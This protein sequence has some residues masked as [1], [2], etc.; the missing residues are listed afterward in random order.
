MCNRRRGVRR[1]RGKR[2]NFITNIIFNQT[3]SIGVITS[4]QVKQINTVGLI[5]IVGCLCR[6]KIF[7]PTVMF[8]KDNFSIP[9]LQLIKAFEVARKG[10]L[11]MTGIRA[12][13]IAIDLISRATKSTG[14]MNA[15]T[16]IKTS[17]TKPLGALV[18]R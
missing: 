18:E 12:S 10:G 8:P 3:I 14:Y 9:F 1:I 7:N 4:I 11:R 2:I 5:K 6:L 17:S 13:G 16:L 15:P